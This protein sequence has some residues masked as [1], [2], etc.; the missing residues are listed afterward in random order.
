MR[1]VGEWRRRLAAL[2]AGSLV[3][4]G[5]VAAVQDGGKE[6]AGSPSE[7]GDAGTT[8]EP[9]SSWPWWARMMC[10]SACAVVF[11]KPGTCSISR[12]TRK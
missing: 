4:A 3:L 6:P 11:E 12:R 9:C 8:G 7:V 10:S 2:F 1:D 5:M